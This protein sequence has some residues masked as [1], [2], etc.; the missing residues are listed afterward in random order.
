MDSVSRLTSAPFLWPWEEQKEEKIQ[1]CKDR[2][3]SLH[4]SEPTNTN[5]HRSK[6]W[7]DFLVFLFLQELK[8][9]QD[10]ALVLNTT[11]RFKVFTLFSA[12]FSLLLFCGDLVQ[13]QSNWF[14]ITVNIFLSHSPW[15]VREHTHTHTPASPLGDCCCTTLTHLQLLLS[16]SWSR[17]CAVKTPS[18]ASVFQE[19]NTTWP[20]SHGRTRARAWAWRTNLSVQSDNGRLPA[21]NTNHRDW[22]TRLVWASCPGGRRLSTPAAEWRVKTWTSPPSGDNP[23]EPS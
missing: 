17:P 9:N 22:R 19:R 5:C 14:I 15:S 7:D 13:N 10:T 4:Q 12:V 11:P 21:T 8:K 18:D 1:E 3:A 6:N 2:V 16:L 20:R 23:H